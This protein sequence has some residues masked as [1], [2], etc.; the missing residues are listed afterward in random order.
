[1]AKLIIDDKKYRTPS[2]QGVF[3]NTQLRLAGPKR[4]DGGAQGGRT[5]PHLHRNLYQ[6][7]KWRIKREGQKTQKKRGSKS[8]LDQANIKRAPSTSRVRQNV[9]HRRG[10]KTKTAPIWG[11][12]GELNEQGPYGGRGAR[13]GAEGGNFNK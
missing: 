11:R 10:K 13:K 6:G 9:E 4:G 1:L 5:R 8:V 7:C 12:N 3:K 2:N